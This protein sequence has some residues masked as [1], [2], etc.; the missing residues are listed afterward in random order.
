MAHFEL[1]ALAALHSL[2][3]RSAVLLGAIALHTAACLELKPGSDELGITTGD[4][5]SLRA[6]ALDADWSCLTRAP[7]LPPP[8]TGELVTFSMPIIESIS[9]LPP[10]TLQVTACQSLDVDC[11][12]P[13]AAPVG[14]SEDGIVHLSLPVGFDGFLEVRSDETTPALFFMHEPL[15]RD[16][17][18]EALPLISDLG[19]MALASNNGAELDLETSGLIVIRTYDCL[20]L[21]APGVALD[22]DSG[23]EVFS[24]VDAFPRV[25]VNVTDAAGLA[26]FMNVPPG[27]TRVI[28]TR[29]TGGQ[30]TGAESLVVRPSWLTFGDLHPF[31]RE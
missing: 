23:G 9:E 19:L 27:F 29:E 12:S 16:T 11:R 31:E 18:S 17:V 21:A 24:F 20:G 13:L 7:A 8:S 25:G 10:L 3:A 1:K 28:G 2:R 6:A 14:P 15:Q 22:N 5:D 30:Q 4:L 26:G